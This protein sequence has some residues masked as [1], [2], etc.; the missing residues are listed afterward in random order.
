MV[1]RASRRDDDDPSSPISMHSLRR[2]ELLLA[3]IWLIAT[4]VFSWQVLA[5]KLVLLLY[6]GWGRVHREH[7]SISS[8][9]RRGPWTL[10]NGESFDNPG[11]LWGVI[12]LVGMMVLFFATYPLLRL[13]LPRHTPR[14]IAAAKAAREEFEFYLNPS[15]RP[16]R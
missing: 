13:L 9:P 7:L 6:C 5:P 8:R 3:P 12:G 14:E 11:D 2:Y 15:D 4:A 16:P 1:K 10:S